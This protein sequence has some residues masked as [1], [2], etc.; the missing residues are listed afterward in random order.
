[1]SEGGVTMDIRV[2]YDIHDVDVEEVG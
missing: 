2:K 1:V